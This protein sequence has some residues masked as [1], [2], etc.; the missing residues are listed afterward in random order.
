MCKA[1]INMPYLWIHQ[2]FGSLLVLGEISQIW[3]VGFHNEL[4]VFCHFVAFQNNH[5]IIMRMSSV[6]SSPPW[7]AYM[8]QWI[9]LAL[10]Q[11]MA[12]RL[13][14]T[15]P[16]SKLMRGYSQLDPYEH[17]SMNYQSKFKTFYSRKCTWKYCLRNGNT[18]FQE[19]DELT[20]IFCLLIHRESVWIFVFSISH[21]L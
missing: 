18:F 3:A 20:F 5:S 12:C 13:F 2:L 15:E 9:E 8:R 14:S 16:L 6:S 19:G 1:W 17:T 7:A 4:F 11:I 21:G 10:V